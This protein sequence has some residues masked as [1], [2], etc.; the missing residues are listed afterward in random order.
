MVARLGVT[1]SCARDIVMA[2]LGVTRS[3]V[4]DKPLSGTPRDM[5]HL[6]CA[7]RFYRSNRG[8]HTKGVSSLSGATRAAV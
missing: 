1:R 8:E 5:V 4:R 6:G 7:R 2:R 3:G